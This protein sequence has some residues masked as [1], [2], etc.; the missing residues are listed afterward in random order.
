MAY[1]KKLTTEEVENHQISINFSKPDRERDRH[2]KGISRR[3]LPPPFVLAKAPRWLKMSWNPNLSRSESRCGKFDE[4]TK[5]ILT[6]PLLEESARSFT[7]F[8]W[9]PDPLLI[10]EDS[11]CGEGD[12]NVCG[13]ACIGGAGRGEDTKAESNYRPDSNNG[14]GSAVAPWELGA[15]GPALGRLSRSSVRTISS[16]ICRNIFSSHNVIVQRRKY[17]VMIS[18]WRGVRFIL[19]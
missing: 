8:P 4:P 16:L 2:P 14:T 13:V 19:R 3:F 15:N 5:R 1:D 6:N 9:S 17:G 10:E 7:G 18:T 12:L 11:S